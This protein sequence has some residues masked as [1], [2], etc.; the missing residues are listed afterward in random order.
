MSTWYAVPLRAWM[1]ALPSLMLTGK[2]ATMRCAASLATASE[3]S[4]PSHTLRRLMIAEGLMNAPFRRWAARLKESGSVPAST[5]QKEPEDSA[6][7]NIV[8]EKEAAD[9]DYLKIKELNKKLNNNIQTAQYRQ[10]LEM[11]E[12]ILATV[13]KFKEKLTAVVEVLP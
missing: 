12:Q 9:P 2:G 1:T 11:T 3:S 4:W 6:H 5:V 8:V 10:A 13:T 7:L